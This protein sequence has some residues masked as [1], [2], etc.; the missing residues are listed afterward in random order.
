MPKFL[1]ST[2]LSHTRASTRL[3]YFVNSNRRSFPLDYDSNLEMQS[4]EHAYTWKEEA[5][6]KVMDWSSSNRTMVSSLKIDETDERAVTPDLFPAG[7]SSEGNHVLQSM[8][9]YDELVPKPIRLRPG[10]HVVQALERVE[11]P[12]PT[13]SRIGDEEWV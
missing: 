7:L 10:G 6:V 3:S 13:R 4:P 11:L 5:N 1:G 9:S 8:D 2:L 12:M